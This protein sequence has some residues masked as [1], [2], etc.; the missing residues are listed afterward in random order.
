MDG[1]RDGNGNL[2]NRDEMTCLSSVLVM[3]PVPLIDDFASVDLSKKTSI[4][5]LSRRV[6]DPRSSLHAFKS[7]VL[8][9][10]SY[11]ETRRTFSLPFG[12]LALN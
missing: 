11:P 6:A 12:L 9:K 4:K 10:T 2:P 1:G 5:F 8:M 7:F 3:R